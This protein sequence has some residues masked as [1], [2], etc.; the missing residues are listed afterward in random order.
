M[1][2][3]AIVK[4]VLRSGGSLP[5]C[6]MLNGRDGARSRRKEGRKNKRRPSGQIEGVDL[7]RPMGDYKLSPQTIKLSGSASEGLS[8]AGGHRTYPA[9]DLQFSR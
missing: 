7:C 5:T 8:P 6:T 9:V 1:P 2:L 4:Y 3:R